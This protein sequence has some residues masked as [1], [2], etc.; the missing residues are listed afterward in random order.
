MKL[1][2]SERFRSLFQE[3]FAAVREMGVAEGLRVADLGAGEGYFTIP[4]AIAVGSAGFVY[5]VEPDQRRSDRIR[6]RAAKEGLSNLRVLT[7]RAEDLGDI[8]SGEVDLAFS[9]FTLHH[10]EDRDAA[11][12]EV[13]RVL[14]DGGTFYVWDRVPGRVFRWGTRQEELGQVAAGFASFESLGRGRTVRAKFR[15]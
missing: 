7:S 12:A 4:A 3:P 10:F 9:A 14:R 1:T 6:A 13:R 11:L 5:S 2:V 8:P 15:K